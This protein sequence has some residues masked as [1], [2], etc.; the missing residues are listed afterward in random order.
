MSCHK[1]ALHQKQLVQLL[2]L[3]AVK[4]ATDPRAGGARLKSAS[5]EDQTKAIVGLQDRCQYSQ[6]EQHSLCCA[7]L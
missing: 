6:T 2:A 7:A 4:G 1:G 3:L 5:L